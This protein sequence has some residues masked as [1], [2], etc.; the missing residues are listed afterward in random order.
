MHFYQLVI[1]TAH[2]YNK[3]LSILDEWEQAK[4]DELTDYQS[5]MYELLKPYYF[6]ALGIARA[7]EVIHKHS[8][9]FVQF[10]EREALRRA[11]QA[12][13]SGLSDENRQTFVHK[14]QWLP[15]R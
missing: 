10:T 2:K 3:K 11:V 12:Q 8:N 13:L 5:T 4:V 6:S 15:G 9:L 14:Q 7:S 1:H